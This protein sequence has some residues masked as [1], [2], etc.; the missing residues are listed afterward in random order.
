MRELV[1]AELAPVAAHPAGS[2]AAKWQSVHLKWN[3]HAFFLIFYSK[4][5]GQLKDDIVDANRARAGAVDQALHFVLVPGEHVGGQRFLAS[6]DELDGLVKGAHGDDGQDW[7][8]NL[9][10]GIHFKPNL[11]PKANLGLHHRVVQ[12]HVQNGGRNEQGVGIGLPSLVQNS[13]AA[14]LQQVSEASENGIKMTEIFPKSLREICVVYDAAVVLALLRLWPVEFAE[15]PLQFLHQ[16][17]LGV[18]ADQN[19]VGRQ[20]GLPTVQP[21]APCQAACRDLQVRVR[22]DNDWPEIGRF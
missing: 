20:A 12:L 16:L 5:T 21:F 17:R 22:L 7:A 3:F 15:H 14:S 9:R 2:N 11:S 8:E 19:V 4:C 6:G 18:L 10:K 1:K 13:A